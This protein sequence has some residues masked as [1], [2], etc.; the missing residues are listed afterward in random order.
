MQ[1]KKRPGTRTPYQWIKETINDLL[2]PSSDQEDFSDS[3]SEEDPVSIDPEDPWEDPP[4]TIPEIFLNISREEV[5][6]DFKLW[7][8]STTTSQSGK[9][10]RH[11]K[12]LL[13]DKDFVDF[14]I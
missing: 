7:T 14:A 1:R 9:Y 3:I 4:D 2:G 6:K 5:R 12:A 8:E 10:L 11:Y 13:I